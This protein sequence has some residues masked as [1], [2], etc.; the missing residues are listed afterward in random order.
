MSYSSTS[1][2][3]LA[4]HFLINHNLLKKDMS[5]D[6]IP[7]QKSYRSFLFSITAY[8]V[9][10][11]IWGL[12]YERHW[13]GLTFLDTQLYFVA[14]AFTV[15]MWTKFA[16]DYLRENGSF[17]KVLLVTGQLIFAFQL[18]LAL[19]TFVRPIMFYF[20]EKGVYHAGIG[21]YI[22]LAAQIVMFVM[23]AIYA[24]SV[25]QKST[26][27]KKA[28]Y[29]IIGM[30]S[31]TMAVFDVLQACYSLLPMYAIGCL[32]GTC[33]LNSFVLENEK[34]EYRDDLEEKLRESIEKGNYYDL[35]TGL[36]SMT[37]FF[38]LAEAEKKE[39]LKRGGKP[40]YL[41][42]DFNGMKFYN[43]KNGFAEG[44]KLL[45]SFAKLLVRAFGNDCCGR[46]GGDHFAAIT[47][48]QGLEDRL[49][50]FLRDNQD[51]NDGRSIPVHV[52]VYADQDQTEDVSLACDRA[53]LACN[54]LHGAYASCYQYYKQELSDDAERR[55]YIVENIDRAIAGKWIQVYYQPIIR[56]VNGKVCDE[57]ALARWIDPTR[58]FLSPASFIP[59]LEESGLIYKLD[60]Y[61]L[62]QVLDNIKTLEA[63]G[64]YIVPHSINL[65][66]SDFDSCDIV[67]EIRRR[68]DEAGVSRDK[69]TIEITE[70]IIGGDFDFI[71][72]KVTQFQRLGFPVWMDDFGSGY[73]SL[74]VLQ[75][76]RFDL[77]KFDMSFMKKLDEGGTGKV[78]LTELMRMATALGLETICEGVE[79]EAHVRFLQEIGCSK[80][81][82]Y[83][84]EKPKP[85]SYG[86]EWFKKNRESLENPA[87]AAYF[88]SIGRVNLYDLSVI[89]QGDENSLHNT[90]N[91][92]PMG[93]IE[94]QGDTAR[95]VRSN[96]SYRDFMKRSFGIELSSLG[97]GFAKFDGAFMNNIVKTCCEQGLRSFYDEKLPDGSVAH[98]LARPIGTNPVTGNMAVAVAVLSV[99]N[100]DERTSYADIAR[101]LA[102]DYYN[103]YI[104]DLDTDRYIEYS[105]LAGG[106]ELSIERHGEDF[107]ASARHDTLTRIYEKDQEAFL[108]RF[109]KENI[110]RELKEQGVF[111]STY[112]LV[113][114]GTPTYVNMKITRMRE[115]GN[116]IILGV[117]I[118]DS[119]MKQKEQLAEIEKERD[120]MIRVMALSDGYMSVITVDLE[121]GHYVEVSSTDDFDSLGAAKQGENFFRQSAIDAAKYFHP[122]DQRRFIEAFTQ[123]NVMR[124]IRRNGC[125]RIQYRLMINGEPR[126]TALKAALFRDRSG[127]KMVVGIRAL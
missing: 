35:L 124:E 120:A 97:S 8:Y 28:R 110:L 6:A 42:L 32:L 9:T 15:L 69:I 46:I 51:I 4:I 74:D 70:S 55:Q 23:T 5:K 11:A 44:D 121:T 116:R 48:A 84:F 89:A 92:L 106:D 83:F 95:F 90:F 93:I 30:F 82:G 112:R 108:S 91:T 118:V 101:A 76:I 64:L 56:A 117:S 22:T 14:M 94:I 36:P 122:D 24:A 13:L 75:S 31:V 50:Q 47:V 109:T 37:T 63:E 39:I 107:F 53:K 99:T 54:E 125:F 65:S 68:V 86:L 45:Q 115:R 123:E 66:R 29:R 61:V 7:A 119:Y 67:E 72:E 80:L 27:M 78:I 34:E 59:A 12:L 81:Q 10:D 113:D 96:Q 100:P 105:T 19:A 79:T 85:F 43:Q 18:I 114:N 87:E 21:R 25:S 88:E 26:G 52:G 57:E 41:Y 103:I 73:S 33:L 16:V 20:D 3:A 49:R 38:E 1:I 127:E 104:V 62:E 126:P 17:G 102:A 71:K 77:L 2:L 60:L 40:A 58:G 111:T 98:S